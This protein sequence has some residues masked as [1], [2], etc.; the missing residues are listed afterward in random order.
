[1]HGQW[2]GSAGDYLRLIIVDG[3]DRQSGG[4]C[5]VMVLKMIFEELWE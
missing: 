5:C 4:R 2:P 1:M 3:G